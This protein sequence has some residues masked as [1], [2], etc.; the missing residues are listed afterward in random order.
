MR[1]FALILVAMSLLPSCASNQF[2]KACSL[3][4][5]KRATALNNI[6]TFMMSAPDIDYASYVEPQLNVQADYNSSS[7]C[8]FV[9]R[10]NQPVATGF[11]WDGTWDFRVD[12]ETLQVDKYRRLHIK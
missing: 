5:D 3:A 8:S 4:T 1:N 2:G 12:K 11:I 9:I 10:P 7:H 6:R